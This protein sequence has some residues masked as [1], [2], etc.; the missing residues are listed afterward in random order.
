MSTAPKR[1]RRW[2]R[3]LLGTVFSLVTGYSVFLAQF[4][5]PSHRIHRRLPVGHEQYP[6]GFA[7]RTDRGWP[8]TFLSKESPAWGVPPV[9]VRGQ[10]LAIDVGLAL[11]IVGSSSAVVFRVR[12]TFSVASCMMLVT[13]MGL[14]LVA[15]SKV[16]FPDQ[17]FLWLTLQAGLFCACIVILASVLRMLRIAV[18]FGVSAWRTSNTTAS[19]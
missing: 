15:R 19:E 16:E 5:N 13:W 17:W 14:F 18:Q 6:G 9:Q 7:K 1:G 8:L 3:F 2:F 4:S 12:R 11:L 10:A